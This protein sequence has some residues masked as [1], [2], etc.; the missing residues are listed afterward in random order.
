MSF[1]YQ[2]TAILIKPVCGIA[3]N[4]NKDFKDTTKIEGGGKIKTYKTEYRDVREHVET[5]FLACLLGKKWIGKL[6]VN[7]VQECW[8]LVVHL[9]VQ[10]KNI[11]VPE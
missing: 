9:G 5:C 1:L 10:E 11:R 6:L 3:D 4:V 2:M 7:L 8:M